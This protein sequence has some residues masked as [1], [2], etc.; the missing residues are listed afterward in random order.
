M[1]EVPSHSASPLNLTDLRLKLAAAGGRR[2]WRG[3]GEVADDPR[4][5]EMLHREFPNRASEW[6]DEGDGFSRRDFLKV[7]AASLAL[8]GLHGGCTKEPQERIVP[9]V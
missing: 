6:L 7:M 2:Y 3:L 1:R 4:F 9:Y 8:A 5:V